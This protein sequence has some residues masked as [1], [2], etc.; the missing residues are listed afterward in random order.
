MIWTLWKMG[1]PLEI[2]EKELQGAFRTK[3]DLRKGYYQELLQY[4]DNNKGI[5]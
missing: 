2:Q 4:N 3:P 1:F 5:N